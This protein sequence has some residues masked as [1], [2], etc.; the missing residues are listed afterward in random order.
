MF[1]FRNKNKKN[2]YLF[3][4]FIAPYNILEKEII[5]KM[6]KLIKFN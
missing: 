2:K 3:I 6:H 5:K 1:S 4:E